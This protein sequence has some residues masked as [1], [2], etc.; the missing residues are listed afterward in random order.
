M[1][2]DPEMASNLEHTIET[3][4]HPNYLENCAQCL[5]VSSDGNGHSD[6]CRLINS[7]STFRPIYGQIPMTMFKLRIEN[8]SD[9]LYVFNKKAG[10]FEV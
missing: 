7:K 9:V 1:H 4:K 5:V 2:R 3:C 6:N 10:I 8:P